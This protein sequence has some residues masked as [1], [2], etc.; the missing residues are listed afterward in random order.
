MPC[1]RVVSYIIFAGA[2]KIAPVQCFRLAELPARAL[3]NHLKMIRFFVMAGLVP[4]I[5]AFL[6]RA[7]KTW[8]PG[9]A[10]KFTQSAQGRLLRPGMTSFHRLH[11]A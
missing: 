4:A 2:T 9:T 10:D 11:F 6:A 8:M 5:H 1:E 3:S 7:R